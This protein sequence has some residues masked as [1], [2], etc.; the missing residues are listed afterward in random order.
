MPRLQELGVSART[1][2]EAGEIFKLKLPELRK[3]NM[4]AGYQYPLDVLGKNR[5]LQKLEEISIEPHMLEPG[6]AESYV[7]GF[8]EFCRSEHLSSLRSLTLTAAEFGDKGVEQLVQA[9]F[10]PQ[11]RT[12]RLFSGT[13]TAAGLEVLADQDLSHLESLDLTQNY[14]HEA[15]ALVEKIRT[16]LPQFKLAY[17]ISGSPGDGD[18]EHLYEGSME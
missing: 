8:A 18:P 3:L 13:I 16:Q 1:Q 5:S 9:P 14:I 4:D 7:S 10:F 17:Q 12:L 15:K 11:L 2:S 6:D